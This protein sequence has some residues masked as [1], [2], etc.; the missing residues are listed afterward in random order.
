MPGLLAA[1][2]FE[3]HWATAVLEAADEDSM[4]EGD[5]TRT[6]WSRESGKFLVSVKPLQAEE[7]LPR[8]R[9]CG[10]YWSV[11]TADLTTNGLSV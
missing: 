6:T 4:E 3:E 2:E 7:A 10:A 11:H 1:L 8:W 9:P 5:V